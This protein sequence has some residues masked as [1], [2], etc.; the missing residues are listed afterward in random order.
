MLAFP[1]LWVL[2][3]WIRSW[4]LSGFPWLFLGISQL[5]SPLRGF[6][7]IVGEYGLSFLVVFTSS[8]LV[9]AYI[10]RTKIFS[11][12]IAMLVII[13]LWISGTLLAKI[14]WT[15]ITDNPI[16][17]ALIQGNIPQQMKWD[18]EY[19]D[20]TLQRYFD[21]S[22]NQWHNQIVIWPE[23]AIPTLYQYAKDYFDQL[24]LIA[25]KNNSTLITGIPVKDGFYY[26][27]GIIALG[28]GQGIYY[29]RH[30][31]PFG[32]YV[33]FDRW[34]RGIIGFF[35]IPMSN[36]AAG[37]ANQGNLQAA[38]LT[39]APFICYEIAYPEL[40]LAAL[41]TANLLLTV[42]N[43]AWFGH[44]FASAQHLQIAQL[45]ALETGRYHLFSNN[46]GVSAVIAPDGT[47]QAATPAFQ[48][49]VLTNSIMKMTGAT[50]LVWLGLTPILG[51]MAGL[52]LLA[53]F[54]EKRNIRK[55]LKNMEYAPQKV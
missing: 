49:T 20:T 55:I 12:L 42:S 10:Q 21:L 38:G 15:K 3:E 54:L 25:K 24:A 2:F 1:A 19:L 16:A 35:D 51:A 29:K 48:T 31:V 53:F 36:F 39:I 52:L 46:T 37:S 32:E 9:L 47:I 7:P 8:L 13:L 6:A 41:P 30:L 50:P 43:D 26:Y 22:K 18:P 45:R 44:S 27:N 34:L 17:V 23:A 14:S 33:P 40:V 4:F 5:S 28:T 11:V